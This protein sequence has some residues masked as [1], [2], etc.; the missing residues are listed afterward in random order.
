MN[1]LEEIVYKYALLNAAKH[2]GSANPGAVIGSI[3]SQEPDL[4]S[5]AKE[6]GPIAGKIVAQVNKL[7]EDEQAS[8]MAKYHVEVKENKQKK[9]EGLQ[10]L[11]GSH[12][13]VVM[14][15]APNPSGPL[16]IGHARAAVPNG[17]YA[18]RYDA[19]LILRIEDTDPKRVFEDA[20]DLIPEDLEWLGITPDEVYYQSDRFDIY[21]DYARKLIEK[22]AAYMCTCDGATFKELKD[23]CKPFK[24]AL[25]M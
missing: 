7:S 11:P 10:E 8:Q 6:I 24:F 21:Y 19:K 20:Y 18:K 9:E 25:E 12:D 4:R 13:T 17:E 23:N 16:H 14:R 22:G 2:K 5:K 15:F 3:M 1:D